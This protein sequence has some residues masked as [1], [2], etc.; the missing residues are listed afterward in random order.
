MKAIG[1]AVWSVPRAIGHGVRRV[2][3]LVHD[4]DDV[5]EIYGDNPN[6]LT[7]DQR[8]AAGNMAANL[9]GGNGTGAM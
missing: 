3:S 4:D 2:F 9:I 8:L 6:G 1:S 5:R 7:D